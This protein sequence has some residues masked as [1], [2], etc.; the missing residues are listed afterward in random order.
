M[1][2]LFKFLRQIELSQLIDKIRKDIDKYQAKLGIK[3][4]D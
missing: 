2:K 4:I 3:I 1:E